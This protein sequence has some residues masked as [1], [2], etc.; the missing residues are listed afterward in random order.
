LGLYIVKKV[1]EAH[2]GSISV[3]ENQP[4]GAIFTATFNEEAA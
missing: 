2:N 4:N 1:I 3:K